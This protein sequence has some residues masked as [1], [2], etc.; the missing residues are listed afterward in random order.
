MNMYHLSCRKLRS[1][2]VMLTAVVCVYI[3]LNVVYLNL[4]AES[5]VSE[6][7]KPS[8][9]QS[10]AARLKFGTPSADGKVEVVVSLNAEELAKLL[11]K[12]D[13]VGG[14]A[15][16]GTKK[17]AA[18]SAVTVHNRSSSPP[19]NVSYILHNPGLCSGLVTSGVS[20]VVGIYSAPEQSERR[21]LLRETWANV[22]L[23][24]QNVFRT[25]FVMG[26]A[27]I[28][29]QES[30]QAEFE[31]Y[32]DI[33]QGNFVDG[34]RNS[35]LKGL[36]SLHFVVHYCTAAKY[37]IKADDDNFLNIFSMM[38]L[39]E[40]SLMH[41]HTVICAL[42]KDNTMPILRDPKECAPWCVAADELPGRTHF[43][44]YCAGL[45][46]AVSH[47][48]VSALYTA[49]L[50]APYFWI[51]DVYITGLLMSE[52]SKEL[53]DIHYIDLNANF[54][55]VEVDAEKEYLDKRKSIHFVTAKIR[56]PEIHKRVWKALVNRLIPSQFKLLSVSA[57][58][59][60]T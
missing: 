12:S 38:H 39:F 19:V 48:L 7:S 42:W 3:V 6:N 25:F 34:P 60:S 29:Q 8:D 5:P 18:K 21:K 43:P 33:V 37:F 31:R 28:A 1:L 26:Q 22:A 15:V 16:E 11:E 44:Q 59:R 51:D 46:Y 36:L 55:L 45:A 54:T 23:F 53:H 24:Q 13:L 50:S 35:T 58:A 52:V 4:T 56:D 17:D 41:Q 20:W 30:I 14:L 2:A 57:I 32:R 9:L 49:S 27:R 47:E 10:V 40:Q